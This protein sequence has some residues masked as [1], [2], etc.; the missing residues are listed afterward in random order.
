MQGGENSQGEA[1]MQAFSNDGRSHFLWVLV[2]QLFSIFL[3]ACKYYPSSFLGN[4]G[5][6][7]LLHLVVD[8]AQAR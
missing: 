1:I 5:G 3:N 6:K 7:M 4:R 2:V 8:T